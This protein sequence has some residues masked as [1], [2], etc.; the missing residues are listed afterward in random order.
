[1]KKFRLVLV[2]ISLC[3]L[4]V[5]GMWLFTDTK[6][7]STTTQ[8]TVVRKFEENQ[9]LWV[10][11]YNSQNKEIKLLMIDRSVWNEMIVN[12]TYI[13]TYIQKENEKPIFVELVPEK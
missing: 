12:K 6:Q 1:M 4:L 7:T 5:M 8:F 3:L 9:K 13:L 11:G 10:Q 2:L